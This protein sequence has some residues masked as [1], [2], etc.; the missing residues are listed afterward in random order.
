MVFLGDTEEIMDLVQLIMD[1]S[2]HKGTERSHGVIYL[3]EW[4]D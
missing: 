3:Y 1:F 2:Y 4:H